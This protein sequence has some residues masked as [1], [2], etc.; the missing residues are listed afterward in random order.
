MTRAQHFGF[1]VTGQAERLQTQLDPGLPAGFSTWPADAQTRWRAMTRSPDP[2]IKLALYNQVV[3]MLGAAGLAP[4]PSP[5][6]VPAEIFAGYYALVRKTA[7]EASLRLRSAPASGSLLL[8]TIPNGESVTVLETGLR[9]ARLGFQCPNCEW[10]RV[11]YYDRSLPYPP[12]EEGFMRAVGPNGERNLLPLTRGL[13]RSTDTNSPIE[14]LIPGA[15]TGQLFP[16]RRRS[17][18]FST[19][20]Y[21]TFNPL[22]QLA[23]ATAVVQQLQAQAAQMSP[24]AATSVLNAIA[25][26]GQEI[27]ELEA[28]LSTGAQPDMGAMEDGPMVATGQVVDRALELYNARQQFS[29]ALARARLGGP[30]W[31]FVNEATAPGTMGEGLMLTSVGPNAPPGTVD[32][33]AP[34]MLPNGTSVHVLDRQSIPGGGVAA[35][36]RERL[37]RA[38]GTLITVVG[39][40]IEVDSTGRRNLIESHARI[41]GLP[42]VPPSTGQFGQDQA[43]SPSMICNVP[44]GCQIVGPAPE[45]RPYVGSF[46]TVPF[47]ERVEVEGRDGSNYV[48]VI[49]REN[50]IRGRNLTRGFLPIS[51]LRMPPAQPSIPITRRLPQRRPGDPPL[52]TPRP[53]PPPI[54]TAA[55]AYQRWQYAI[56]HGLPAPVVEALRRTHERLSAEEAAAPPPGGP[57]LTPGS[58]LLRFL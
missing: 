15:G 44:G 52:G 28:L 3:R 17:R 47:G 1:P 18:F 46:A 34:V 24:A 21:A 19:G 27:D 30:L 49:Y 20:P 4:P 42:D 31:L 40:V 56:A 25:E 7:D 39:W 6:L 2:A 36:V 35:Q 33:N 37:Q 50:S 22:E 58:P 23:M 5:D 54:A 11:R 53:A 16:F 29:A 8:R 32:A 12:A 45:R 55:E 43:I 51:A 9:E 13:Q 26:L 57:P 14:L 38:D 41:V 48:A 10:W